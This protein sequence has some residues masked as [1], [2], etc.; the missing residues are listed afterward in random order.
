[1]ENGRA[2]FISAEGFVHKLWLLNLIAFE[3]RTTFNPDLYDIVSSPFPLWA[4]L[5]TEG[6]P[7]SSS[8]RTQ[9][10]IAFL[11]PTIMPPSRLEMTSDEILVPTN[12]IF[13]PSHPS[14][15]HSA[16]RSLLTSTS[17]LHGGAFSWETLGGETKK[18]Y[19][20]RETREGQGDVREK[21]R[22]L[23]ER[24]EEEVMAR[25]ET[26]GTDGWVAYGFGDI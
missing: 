14:S 18:S 15:L 9:K 25:E 7:R 13:S 23:L 5:S 16:H 19:G 2:A 12:S 26:D 10:C 3:D 4:L 24:A 21:W 1:M 22:D 20:W 17:S 8:A 6:D 11:I